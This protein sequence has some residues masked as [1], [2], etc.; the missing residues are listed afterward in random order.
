MKKLYYEVR[1]SAENMEQ[2]RTILNSLVDKRLSTGGQMFQAPAHF[3]WK[4]NK[5][6][7]PEYVT[8]LTYTNELCKDQLMDDV[9]KTSVEEV[10]MVT[11]TLPDD[12]AS[13]LRDYIDRE[14]R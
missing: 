14:L 13:E 8:I 2:A 6:S 1:I 3:L 4:G 10:P 9:R 5:N 12:L 11:F 7:M